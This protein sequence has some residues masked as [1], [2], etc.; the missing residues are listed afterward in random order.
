[1]FVD[2]AVIGGTRDEV[3]TRTAEFATLLAELEDEI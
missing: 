1:V 2:G 3:P